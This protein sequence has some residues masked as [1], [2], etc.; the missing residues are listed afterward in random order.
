MN[1]LTHNRSSTPRAWLLHGRRLGDTNQLHA[2]AKALNIPFEAKELHYNRLRR[3]RFLRGV[4]LTILSRDSR[5]LI[6]PPWPDLVIG[7]GYGSVHVARE[8]RRRSG[9]RTKLVQVGNPRTRVDDM[10]LVITTPQYAR[11]PAPN[12]LALPYAMGNPARAVAATEQERE[13]LK[14]YPKPIRLLA[15]GGPAR[16]WRLD[17]DALSSA[18]DKLA[19]R[20]RSNGGTLI[21][22]TSQRTTDSERSFVAK[23]LTGKNQ[24]LVDTFP[25]FA[26][27]LAAADEIYVTADSVSMISEA[28]L[29][30]K[31]VGLVPIARSARGK[32]RRWLHG[33]GIVGRG[34]P[35]F[36]AFW[37]VLAGQAMAGDVDSPVASR[38]Q[39][40]VELAARAVRRLLQD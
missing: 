16:Y 23:R 34:V 9:D 32:I 5:K 25:R 3:I 22:V 30:G 4:R 12:V 6:E 13:W 36:P 7:V 35:D 18:I 11:P 2:L 39:D 14:A 26:V 8:I 31:P 21:I 15:V 24:V 17:L 10:D 40:S 37:R 1:D 19:E 28:V 38:A 33:C 27:L 29:T 20:S